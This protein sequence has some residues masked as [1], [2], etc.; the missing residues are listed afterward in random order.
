MHL[1]NS[2]IICSHPLPRYNVAWIV[3]NVLN[4]LQTQEPLSELALTTHKFLML[5]T[6]LYRQRGQTLQL[7]DIRNIS[8]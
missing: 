7:L 6:L 5:L 4:Y 1:T 3:D 2:A 8:K